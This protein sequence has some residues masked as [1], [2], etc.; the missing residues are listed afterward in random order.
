MAAQGEPETTTQKFL[1][2]KCEFQ[3]LVEEIEKNGL[4]AEDDSNAKPEEI[5]AEANEMRQKLLNMRVSSSEASQGGDKQLL[6][7]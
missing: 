2:L 3:E 4:G 7:K 1:R 6:K 5:I